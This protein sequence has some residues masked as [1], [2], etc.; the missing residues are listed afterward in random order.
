MLH[1]MV[2]DANGRKMSKSVGNV[3]DPLH[4]I[5]GAPLELLENEL[6]DGRAKGSLSGQ[7]Y[8]KALAVLRKD[9]PEG[10]P[11]CGADALR[12]GLCH[13]DVSS[14]IHFYIYF[15]C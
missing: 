12:Y 2:C 14:K 1:G 15:G 10:M 7:D 3:I 13:N 11:V 5:D 9:F 8:S 6:K 4:I